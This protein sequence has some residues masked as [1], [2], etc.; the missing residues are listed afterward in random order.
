MGG[1]LW[2]AVNSIG[3]K[4]WDT[5]TSPI[6]TA[7]HAAQNFTYPLFHD[8]SISEH[9]NLIAT[10]ISESYE[11]DEDERADYVG[12]L[13]RDQDLSTEYMDVWVDNHRE[14]PYALISVRGSAKAKDFLVDDAGILLTGKSR[15]LIQTD[16][17]RAVD[18]YA[19][20]GTVEVAGHSLG[21]TLVS[22]ALQGDSTILD[23][24]DRVDFFNRRQ[25]YPIFLMNPRLISTKTKATWWDWARCSTAVLQKT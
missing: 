18:K 11:L 14:P 15:N 7:W 6:R 4:I 5:A 3:K 23:K 1:G 25:S 10:C 20:A 16:L 21:T 19:D 12:S 2:D 9:T 24:I 8:H 17:K 13:I 22:E